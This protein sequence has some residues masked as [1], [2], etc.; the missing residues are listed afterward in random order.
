L[1]IKSNLLESLAMNKNSNIY[2]CSGLVDC[3]K[4]ELDKFKSLLVKIN[5]EQRF[6]VTYADYL[7]IHTNF[8]TA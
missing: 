2:I 8:N 4:S 5:L 7:T 3:V 1:V 6:T